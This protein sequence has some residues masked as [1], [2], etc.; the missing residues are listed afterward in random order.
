MNTLSNVYLDTINPN[1]SYN[2]LLSIDVFFSIIAHTFLYLIIIILVSKL[3]SFKISKKLF[4]NIIIVLLFVMTFGYYGRLARSKSIFNTLISN[5]ESK[6]F[7]EK[8][9]M[10]IMHNAYFTYYFLG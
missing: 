5:G 8:E 3:F 1:V 10:D 7:A 2:R 6:E 9:T 4:R